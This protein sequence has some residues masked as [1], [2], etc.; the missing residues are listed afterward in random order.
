MKRF[1]DIFKKKVKYVKYFDE[2]E[3]TLYIKFVKKS[4]F[5]RWRLVYNEDRMPRVYRI[6]NDK[7][8]AV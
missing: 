6:V 2:G 1:V 4:I 7:I 3:F 8:V 5:G